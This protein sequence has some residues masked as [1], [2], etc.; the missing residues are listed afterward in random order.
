[1]A[2]DSTRLEDKNAEKA[3]LEKLIEALKNPSSEHMQIY[4]CLGLALA[5]MAGVVF[6]S[7]APQKQIKLTLDNVIDESTPKKR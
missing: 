5:V 6:I 3:L 4:I 2:Q 1:L 7:L